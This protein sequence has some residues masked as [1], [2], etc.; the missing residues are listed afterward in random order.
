[1]RPRKTPAENAGSCSG[2]PSSCS[3]C[4]NEAAE[5][6]R[7]KPEVHD[8]RVDSLCRFNEAAEN[9]R[10]KRMALRESIRELLKLQ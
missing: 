5:N 9:T 10:G 4:F 3:R 1:M 6:T 2:R 8:H 7:G